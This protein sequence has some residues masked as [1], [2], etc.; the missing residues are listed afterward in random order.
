MPALDSS[1]A[2]ALTGLVT[3]QGVQMF[4]QQA[5]KVSEVRRASPSDNGLRADLR[6][7]E[8]QAGSV[9]VL[10]GVAVSSMTGEAAP[11]WLAIAT[12]ALMVGIYEYALARPPNAPTAPPL[13][14]ERGDA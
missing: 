12:T 14:T 4:A 11:M 10:A 13:T 1:T 5:P 2:V 6:V 8:L 3:M 9:M 7:A